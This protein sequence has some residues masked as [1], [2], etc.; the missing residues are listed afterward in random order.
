MIPGINFSDQALIH[1]SV[2][3]TYHGLTGVLLSFARSA[4]ETP[5]ESTH[6]VRKK[7]KLFR[8]FTKLARLCSDSAAYSAANMFLR[9]LGRE[10]SDLR[11]AHV[12]RFHLQ[13]CSLPGESSGFKDLITELNLFNDEII[14]RIEKEILA[15]D[16]R[17]QWFADELKSNNELS[18]YFTELDV[19][20]DQIMNAYTD[21]FVKS[22]QA[23][24]SGILFPDA[25]LIHEWRKRMKDL[26][27]QTELIA[28]ESH[29]DGI[30][31]YPAVELL[32]D[33]LGE[34]NDLH[35]LAAWASEHEKDLRNSDG[36][37]AWISE[38]KYR[39]NKLH[40]ESEELGIELYQLSSMDVWDAVRS[41]VNE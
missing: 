38:L 17:F 37:I 40:R 13:E 2:T 7:L 29:T 1:Q 26:Q 15:V 3:E 21:T 27:Y 8:A 35:M 19:S 30:S 23:F 12:R 5:E 4:K 10:F 31:F 14:S 36:L 32:C 20:E 24:E 16:N 39:K 22:R 28:G 25:E 6:Q 41:A 34:M 33:H 9:N 18:A 11:D